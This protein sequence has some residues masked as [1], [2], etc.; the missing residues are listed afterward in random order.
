MTSLSNTVQN[1]RY[2]PD[3]MVCVCVRVNAGLHAVK[4][5]YVTTLCSFSKN[6]LNVLKISCLKTVNINPL[7]LELDI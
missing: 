7:V 5:R 3:Y 6:I 4:S 1:P 2:T